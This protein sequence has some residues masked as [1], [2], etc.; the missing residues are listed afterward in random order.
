MDFMH[1]SG[2]TVA[3]R[4]LPRAGLALCVAVAGQLMLT[5]WRVWAATTLNVST[6]AD[7][8]TSTGACGNPAI[9]TPPSP[10]SLREATCIA[11]NLGASTVT[12]N[13]PA[14]TYHVTNGELQPG[15]V[16][17]G[18]IT[19]TGAGQAST[20][21]DA[22]G[23]SRGDGGAHCDREMQR[24]MAAE[25]RGMSGRWRYRLRGDTGRKR[26]QVILNEDRS[27]FVEPLV[28]AQVIAQT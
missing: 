25:R 1:R 2:S 17:G 16:S 10:L 4:M 21:I 26:G 19:I 7:V 14:G 5:P 27:L 18:D 6:T 15:K 28:V 12:I 23:V 11:D 9:T 20:V 8:T 3:R 22:G 24:S 13:V